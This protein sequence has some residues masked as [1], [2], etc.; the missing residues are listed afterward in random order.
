VIAKLLVGLVAFWIACAS[1][2]A[3]QVSDPGTQFVPEADAHIQLPSNL[4][5]LAFVGLPQG[6]GYSYQQQYVA[7][8]LGYQFKSILTPHLINIDPDKE[9][10]VLFGGGYEFL[11]TMQSGNVIEE[12]RAIMDGIFRFR[13]SPR[14]LFVDRNR[15]EFRWV[16]GAYSTTYRQKMTL[17]RDYLIRGFKFTPYGSGEIFYNGAQHSWNLDLYTGGIQWPY[18]SFFMLDTYYQRQVCGICNP[19]DVNIAGARFN[20][21]M[22]ATK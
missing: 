18:K 7:A 10:Y 17:S 8:G 13:P 11:R 12:N 19:R 14:F 6:A 15:F 1:G 2:Q 22:S 3:Q 4:R 16:N 5:I 20:F 21:Y 9:H